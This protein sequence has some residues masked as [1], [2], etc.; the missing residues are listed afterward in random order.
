MMA[1]VDRD[2]A[3]SDAGYKD[4]LF[5]WVLVCRVGEQARSSRAKHVIDIDY[6]NS[7]AQLYV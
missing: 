4:L 5:M 2:C 1:R 7:S 6:A 3:H